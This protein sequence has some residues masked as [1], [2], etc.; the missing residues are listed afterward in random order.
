MTRPR[1]AGR[2]RAAYR[3]GKGTACGPVSGSVCGSNAARYAPNQNN[4]LVTMT[5]GF[6]YLTQARAAACRALPE[7]LS[8]TP[9]AGR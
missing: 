9:G 4:S 7:R 6:R 1:Y 3:I 5:I 8:T 2:M